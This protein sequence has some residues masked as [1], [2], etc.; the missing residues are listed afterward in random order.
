MASLFNFAI[1]HVTSLGQTLSCT[2]HHG[3]LGLTVAEFDCYSLRK[4]DSLH[5][6]RVLGLCH[7]DN[8]VVGWTIFGWILRPRM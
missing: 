5:R 1:Y 4:C 2:L 6:L 7:A 3:S 8:S